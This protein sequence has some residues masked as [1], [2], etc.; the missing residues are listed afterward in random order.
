MKNTLRKY[1]KKKIALTIFLLSHDFHRSNGPFKIQTIATHAFLSTHA[2][3]ERSIFLGCDF[4][5][6]KATY[7]DEA[8][9]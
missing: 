5:S 4:F 3:C 6:E 8:F 2:P 1:L 7:I 9:K